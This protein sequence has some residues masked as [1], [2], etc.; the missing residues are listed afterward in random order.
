M[1]KLEDLVKEVNNSSKIPTEKDGMRYV[2]I[3]DLYSGETKFK[4][5][6]ATKERDPF[7][8]DQE[9]FVFILDISGEKEY[10]KLTLRADPDGIREK[11]YNY[12]NENGKIDIP[13]KVVKNGKFFSFQFIEN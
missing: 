7:N 1:I 6:S 4:F 12:L 3:N 2:K 8:Q 11:I 9:R 13:C 10:K 5:V